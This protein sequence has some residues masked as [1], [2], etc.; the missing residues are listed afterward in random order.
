M[1]LRLAGRL[2]SDRLEV[3]EA[4]EDSPAGIAWLGRRALRD[5]RGPTATIGRERVMLAGLAWRRGAIA[6]RSA[7]ELRRRLGSR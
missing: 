2:T 3:L 1:R 4:I 5:L 7:R 6:R